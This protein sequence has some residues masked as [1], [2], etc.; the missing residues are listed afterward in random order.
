MGH[1]WLPFRVILTPPAWCD[2]GGAPQR[3]LIVA[4]PKAPLLTYCPAPSLRSRLE[5]ASPTSEEEEHCWPGLSTPGPL[6]YLSQCRGWSTVKQPRW[7]PYNSCQF[8]IA[9]CTQRSPVL[10]PWSHLLVPSVRDGLRGLHLSCAP[11]GK[12]SLLLDGVPE[13]SLAAFSLSV[14]HIHL[15]IPC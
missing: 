10:S 12:E 13:P 5:L 3:I 15:E 6:L 4:H 9:T 1:S 7:G 2:G 8:S 11:L 14:P